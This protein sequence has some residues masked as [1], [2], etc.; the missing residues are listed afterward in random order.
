MEKMKTENVFLK[1]GF[2]DSVHPKTHKKISF[3]GI[4]TH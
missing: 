4:N 2:K 3:N 1:R